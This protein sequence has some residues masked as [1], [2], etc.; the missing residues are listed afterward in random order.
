VE[1]NWVHS[2]L[3][4]PIGLLCQPRVIMMMEKLVEWS[5]GETEVLGENLPQCRF[6]HHKPHMPARTRTR[7][8]TVGSQWLTAWATARPFKYVTDHRT[9]CRHSSFVTSINVKLVAKFSIL[10]LIFYGITWNYTFFLLHSS[11]SYLILLYSLFLLFRF[12]DYLLF[13][14]YDPLCCYWIGCY[15]CYAVCCTCVD[16]T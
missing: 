10:L 6:V 8:A 7:A 2:A 4:P 3:R 12:I 13:C 15:R 11:F 16:A 14:Y 5:A 9:T 1:S